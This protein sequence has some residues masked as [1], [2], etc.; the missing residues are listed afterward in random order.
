MSSL[1]SPYAFALFC[2]DSVAGIIIRTHVLLHTIVR[3]L[4]RHNLI[5]RQIKQDQILLLTS[6]GAQD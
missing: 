4:Q 6:V 2:L 3:L 5:H 1:A